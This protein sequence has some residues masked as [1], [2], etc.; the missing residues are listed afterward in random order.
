MSLWPVPAVAAW[1][2]FEEHMDKAT[3]TQFCL[4]CHVMSEYGQSL[5]YDDKSYIPS[6][7]YNNNFVPREHACYTCHTDYGMLARRRPR[8]MASI[9][10][11]C[12]IWDR[13]K[14]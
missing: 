10:Y 2:G 7:H 13:A 8:S 11:W 12:S 3:S 9:T 1:G 6:V 5:H 14:A 4:S